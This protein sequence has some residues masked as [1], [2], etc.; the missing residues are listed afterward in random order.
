MVLL[1]GENEM[2][3]AF[4]GCDVLELAAASLWRVN[5]QDVISKFDK[6]RSS[7][8]EG[9]YYKAPDTTYCFLREDGAEFAVRFIRA[10]SWR[11]DVIGYWA[12]IESWNTEKSPMIEFKAWLEDQCPVQ[13]L[14]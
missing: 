6:A 4:K 1:E 13:N 3:E 14:N 10:D 11:W 5:V 7:Y 12:G 2:R 9:R 8:W